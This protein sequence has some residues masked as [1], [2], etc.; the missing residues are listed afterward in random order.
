MKALIYALQVYEQVIWL[1]I[2]LEEK[3]ELKL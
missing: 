1:L 2:C 3:P